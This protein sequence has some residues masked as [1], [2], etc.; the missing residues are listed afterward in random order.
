LPS[1]HVFASFSV[2]NL[3]IPKRDMSNT[4]EAAR[5]KASKKLWKECADGTLVNKRALGKLA[6]AGADMEWQD[7]LGFTCLMAAVSNGRLKA[8]ELLL[9]H[10]A[11]IEARDGTGFTPLISAAQNGHTAVVNALLAAGAE[12]EAK[13]NDGATALFG[14][15]QNGHVA[16]VEALLAAGADMEAKTNDGCTPLFVAAQN[17]HIDMVN[18][19]LVAGAEKCS[20]RGCSE[21]AH[22]R[23]RRTA[24]CRRQCRCARS[25]WCNASAHG[26]L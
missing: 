6:K 1:S 14:A 2:A 23:S 3:Q 20:L 22:P 11:N 16:V 13:T 24:G 19:L 5:E 17:G 18:A 4:K 10:G 25:R 12:K 26:C 21:G 15:A 9:A 8:V 7:S